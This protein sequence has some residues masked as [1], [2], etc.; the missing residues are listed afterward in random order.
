VGIVLV[1]EKNATKNGHIQM[2]VKCVKKSTKS[3]NR[4]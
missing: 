3:V 2:Y 4:K 1:A